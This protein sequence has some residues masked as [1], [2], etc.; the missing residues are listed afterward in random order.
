[1]VLILLL[2]ACPF[3]QAILAAEPHCDPKRPE[4]AAEVKTAQPARGLPG[5]VMAA[6]STLSDEERAMVARLEEI[7]TWHEAPA[8][9]K[10]KA[11]PHNHPLTHTPHLRV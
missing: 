11:Q 6:G 3:Q 10:T 5:P 2:T 7:D 8:A 1:M 9:H 4:R